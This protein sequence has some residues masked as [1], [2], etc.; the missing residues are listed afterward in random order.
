MRRI[1]DGAAKYAKGVLT[2]LGG[3]SC[4]ACSGV[5]GQVLFERFGVASAHVIP[6][7]LVAAGIVVLAIQFAR[8]GREIF[9]PWKDAAMRRSMLLFVVFGAAA[10]QFTYF[11]TTYYSNAAWATAICYTSSVLV[12]CYCALRMR[13]APSVVRICALVAVVVGVVL[14]STH[15]QFSSLA[16]S[17]MALIWGCAAAFTFSFCSVQPAQ[18]MERYG[19]L[20]VNGW[21]FLLGGL[22]F[23]VLSRSWELEG[24]WTAASIALVLFITLGG[25]V[26][27][28][29]LYLKGTTMVGP[30]DASMLVTVEVFISALLT[31]L[32][33]GA[34]LSVSDYV[35]FVLIV[36]AGIAVMRESN[37]QRAT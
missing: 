9:R 1:G 26:L 25:T 6:L 19:N 13:K 10:N 28:Y 36:C 23:S 12:A 37:L 29:C 16:V 35:G 24:T 32:V 14:M 31:F 8:K 18:L 34:P 5:A 33:T 21:G 30:Q 3:S 7:C 17:P 15:G 27:G 22:L 2:T 11:Q 4:W 20:T